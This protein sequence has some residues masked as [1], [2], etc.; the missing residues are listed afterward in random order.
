MP[1]LILWIFI[2]FTIGNPQPMGGVYSSKDL[3]LEGRDAV[4]SSNQV[5]SISNC[6]PLKLSS[7]VGGRYEENNNGITTQRF[8]A[9]RVH[10]VR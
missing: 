2:S 8:L 10:N 7:P 9:G 4:I 1:T 3:C 5:V 6:I